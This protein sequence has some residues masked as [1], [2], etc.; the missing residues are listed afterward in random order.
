MKTNENLSDNS[1]SEIE[2]KRCISRLSYVG[3]GFSQELDTALESLR[4]IVML[5]KK[6]LI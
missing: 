2:L 5:S 4:Q 6:R 3:M 1:E